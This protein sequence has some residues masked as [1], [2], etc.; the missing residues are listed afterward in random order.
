MAHFEAEWPMAYEEMDGISTGCGL[1]VEFIVFLNARDDIA[2]VAHLLDDEKHASRD[3]SRRRRNEL[4]ETITAMF[5]PKSTADKELIIATCCISD[6]KV[7]YEDL[8]VRLQITHEVD[9]N[10]PGV[11]L[12]AEAGMISGCGMNGSGLV[13]TGNWLFTNADYV[14]E[15]GERCFPLTCINRWLLR[16]TS[17]T[18]AK[19][20]AYAHP[21]HTSRHVLLAAISGSLSLEIVPHE[22]LYSDRERGAAFSLHGNHLTVNEN[23]RRGLKRPELQ[24]SFENPDS[25]ARLTKLQDM[26][27]KCIGRMSNSL[28]CRE[29]LVGVFRE[30]FDQTDAGA[31]TDANAD[32]NADADENTDGIDKTLVSFVWFKPAQH[33]FVTFKSPPE[34]PPID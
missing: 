33:R 26:I 17:V 32:D 19:G 3:W 1:P 29:E 8:M 22:V 20:Q 18:E 23:F 5:T 24:D 21:R 9:E 11:H 14:P 4:D 2:A 30:L 10:L 25:K 28:L 15:R 6:R 13:V 7:L 16:C 27:T 34:G 31:N 12:L